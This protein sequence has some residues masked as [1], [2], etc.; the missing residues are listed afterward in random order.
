LVI[1]FGINLGR[2]VPGRVYPALVAG[3]YPELVIIFGIN[4]GRP[5]PGGVL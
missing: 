3:Q 4:L 1:F 2:P 5:V